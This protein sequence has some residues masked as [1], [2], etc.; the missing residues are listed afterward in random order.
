MRLIEYY[1]KMV[2]GLA[3]LASFLMEALTGEDA[4]SYRLQEIRVAIP[5]NVRVPFFPDVRAYHHFPQGR[6]GR[7]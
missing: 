1:N 4:F 5:R 7:Y 6:C 2:N 3:A